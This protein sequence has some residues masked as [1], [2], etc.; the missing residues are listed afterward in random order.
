MSS[1]VQ[2]AGK[3]PIAQQLKTRIIDPLSLTSFQ[4][5]L[6]FTNQAHWAVG[7]RVLNGTIQEETET[8]HYWKH[9]AGGYKSN[10]KDFA[11]FAAA[12]AGKS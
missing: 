3:Q 1:V 7:Y 2:A 5:D 4:L 9:G 6:P 10:I 11:R 8:A 12:L